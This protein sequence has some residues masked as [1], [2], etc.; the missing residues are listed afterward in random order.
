MRFK[1]NGICFMGIIIQ[2]MIT[3][4]WAA[5]CDLVNFTGFFRGADQFSTHAVSNSALTWSEAKALAESAGGKLAVITTAEKNA[6]ISSNL[7]GFFGTVPPP[8]TGSKAWIGLSTMSPA[9]PFCSTPGTCT[10]FP[11]RFTWDSSSSGFANYAAGQPDNYCTAEEKEMNPDK[12]C[13]GENWVA[14]DSAGEWSDEGDHGTTTLKLPGIVEWKES[15]ECVSGGTSLSA[16]GDPSAMEGSFCADELKMAIGECVTA[17]DG[18]KF[19][20]LDQAVCLTEVTP[21][22]ISGNNC[23]TGTLNIDTGKCEST[24][25][26]TTISGGTTP[27]YTCATGTLVDLAAT[28]LSYYGCKTPATAGA[29]ADGSVYNA[30]SDGCVSAAQLTDIP[31]ATQQSFC[32]TGTLDPVANT[33]KIISDPSSTPIICPPGTVNPVTGKCPVAP[34]CPSGDF[35]CVQTEAGGQFLC[36]PNSCQADTSGWETTEDTPVGADDK[37]NDGAKAADGTCLGN[38]YIFNGQDKR[39]RKFDNTGAIAAYAKIIAMLILI[40]TGAGAALAAALGGGMLGAAAAAAAISFSTNMTIDGATQG[41]VTSAMVTRNGITA[42]AAGVTAGVGFTAPVEGA[43]GEAA[44]ATGLEGVAQSATNAAYNSGAIS[45]E[46][47]EAIQPIVQQMAAAVDTYTPVLAQGMGASFKSMK[48]CYPDTPVSMACEKDEMGEIS[49]AGNGYCHIIG[50]YCA[51]KMLSACTVKKETSCCFS[52]MLARII[53]EQGRPDIEA[54]GVDGGWG[55]VKAPNCR[56]F[57]PFEF[58]AI[59]FDHIDFTEYEQSLEKSL[60]KAETIRN[61]I[62]GDVGTLTS[63]S[64][65]N[66]G[67]K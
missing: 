4:V 51:K 25:P 34:F 19:C 16:V 31:S 29:C 63:E 27:T 12:L 53:H 20:P 28:G 64:L 41:R 14:M 11:Q 49:M 42:I 7:R 48:C 67:E 15:L 24:I 62:M 30:L 8:G 17:Q 45:M 57:T 38:I 6:E 13:Y 23:A 37:N 40:C 36:S 43:G 5:P 26:A 59:H 60:P 39:C 66:V 32:A 9:G 56:G 22:S 10:P 3:S 61:T 65:S 52:S 33:C 54:F 21:T 2:M 44:A 55:T 47:L 58:Q 50:T 35:P 1:L 46:T 18:S